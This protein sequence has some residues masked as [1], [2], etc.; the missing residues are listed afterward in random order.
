V[1]RLKWVPR[2]ADALFTLVAFYANG[3]ERWRRLIPGTL[4]DINDSAV[5][6]ALTYHG[7]RL[8]AAG[9]ISNRETFRDIALVYVWSNDGSDFDPPSAGAQDQEQED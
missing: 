2:N 3:T 1:S 7:D 5:A 8:V 9:I 6:V 4:P